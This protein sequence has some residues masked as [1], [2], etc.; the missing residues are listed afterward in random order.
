MYAIKNEHLKNQAAFSLIEL[1]HVIVIIGVL[2]A[3]GA[4]AYLRYVK[5]ARAAEANHIMHA[6]IQYC[7][8]YNRARLADRIGVPWPVNAA[9]DDKISAGAT[10]P[11]A[12]LDEVVGGDAYY[13]VYK[14][15]RAAG[16]AG[17]ALIEA[18]GGN[19]RTDDAGTLLSAEFIITD[20]LQYD[21][22]NMDEPWKSQDAM[23]NIQPTNPNGATNAPSADL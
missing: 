18:E 3:L 23:R 10:N 2:A 9:T 14:F 4:P 21:F 13:F 17:Q 19:G 5:N 22:G 12:W 7:Q 6:I 11:A 16:T 8:S 20:M 1:M 15:D